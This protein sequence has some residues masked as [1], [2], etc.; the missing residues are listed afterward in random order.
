MNK[1][2]QLL[3]ML[4]HPEQYTERQWQDI[5]ADDECH[6]LYSLMPKPAAPLP[7]SKPTRG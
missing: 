5:L 6:E 7:A 4:E 2:D 1:T 3:M